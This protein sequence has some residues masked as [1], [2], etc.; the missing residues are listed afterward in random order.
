MYDPTL[1]AI[2]VATNDALTDHLWRYDTATADSGDPIAQLAISLCQAAQEFN[3]TATVLAQ[4]L[5]HIPE[6]C[7][8]Q[9]AAVTTL[10]STTPHTLDIGTLHV[11]HQFERFDAQRETLL[12][13]YAVWRRH[14]RPYHD[15]GLRYLCRTRTTREAEWSP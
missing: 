11:A 8:R 4:T 10:A 2:A 6:E 5:N 9:L 14:R 3:A 7:T 13:L 12:S 1:T 15:P